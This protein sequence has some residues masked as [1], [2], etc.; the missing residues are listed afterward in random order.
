M[1]EARRQ[2]TR[3]AGSDARMGGVPVWPR[4]W[5]E[6]AEPSVP[7][8]SGR[9]ERFRARRVLALAAIGAVVLAVALPR[10]VEAVEPGLTTRAGGGN[11]V[12]IV[13]DAAGHRFD[14]GH[15]R[16]VEA[17]VDGPV[18]VA[19]GRRV[20][21]LDTPGATGPRTGGWQSFPRRLSI[22]VDGTLQAVEDGGETVTLTESG[23]V[24]VEPAPAVGTDAPALDPL[25]Q[26]Q[27]RAQGIEHPPRVFADGEGPDGLRWLAIDVSADPGLRPADYRLLRF[28]G[29]EWTIL[30]PDQG[31]PR[32]TR[33]VWTVPGPQAPIALAVDQAGR[34][35]FS[36]DL[37]GLWVADE[38]GA[39]RVRFP[40]LGVGALDLASTPD[41]AVW[42]ASLRGGLF[43]WS[44]AE[45]P[46][47]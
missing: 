23:W 20:L 24:P 15:V 9:R 44:P 33:A 40:G 37:N 4:T 28:D 19:V 5:L 45:G 35:W 16:E 46:I 27:L 14:K 6:P 25:V 26:E 10:V 18:W 31:I 41:G 38:E 36:L 1:R 2:A 39:E 29:T 34:A 11:V 30:G 12:R 7:N 42:I 32:D 3:Q 22:A 43:C 21:A 13:S 47:R 8:A 17:G